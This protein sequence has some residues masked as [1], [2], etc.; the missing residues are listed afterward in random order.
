MPDRKPII[1][2]H[3]HHFKRQL[4]LK[5]PVVH[6]Q[7]HVIRNTAHRPSTQASYTASRVRPKRG[8]SSAAAQVAATHN[9]IPSMAPHEFNIILRTTTDVFNVLTL[10]P[11]AYKMNKNN[12]REGERGQ[13][14]YMQRV[15]NVASLQCCYWVL[16]SICQCCIVW[17]TSINK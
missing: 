17:F 7:L 16:L 8:I 3:Y 14:N 13:Q 2:L 5:W 15:E 12:K 4:H 10:N 11:G 9:I 6:Q 1:I